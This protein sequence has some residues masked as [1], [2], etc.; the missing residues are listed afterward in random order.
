MEGAFETVSDPSDPVAMPS[1]QAWQ[2]PVPLAAMALALVVASLV[3]GL[4]VSPAPNS[5]SSDPVRLSLLLPEGMRY[6]A[7]NSPARGLAISP[8]NKQ[9][10]F[11][12][13]KDGQL[14]LLRRTLG[15]LSAQPIPGT[16]GPYVELEIVKQK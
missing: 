14:Q 7:V 15:E 11:S 13:V 2:R 5:A 10:V 12:G 3:A 16:Q 4:M 6:T 1:L 9:V 8:D